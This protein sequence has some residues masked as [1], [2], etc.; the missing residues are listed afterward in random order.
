M[1]HPLCI[2]HGNCAD[3]ITAAWLVKHR[4]SQETEFFAAHYGENPPDVRG[5]SVWI[6]D[7]SYPRKILEDMADAAYDMHVLDH[8]RTAQIDLAE[9]DRPN[10]QVVFDMQRSG[11]QITYDVLLG[12]GKQRP[13]IVEY[14]ADRD[15]W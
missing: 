14:T 4:V 5:R 8:H 7:F 11:A 13:K 10:V 9:F 1:A 12:E 2:Y 15:L 3:G 6:V